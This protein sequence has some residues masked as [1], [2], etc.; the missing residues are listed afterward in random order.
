MPGLG[1][2][3]IAFKLW[4]GAIAGAVVTCLAY[5]SRLHKKLVM[6]GAL[7]GAAAYLVASSAAELLGD[8]T[9]AHETLISY[10]GSGAAALLAGVWPGASEA[11]T[12][13]RAGQG[14]ASQQ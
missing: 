3:L 13:N 10:L 6:R 11:A 12:T 7:F 14:P 8:W 5:R 1:A 9:S 2:L 4:M